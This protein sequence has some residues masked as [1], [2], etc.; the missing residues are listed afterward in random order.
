MNGPTG[1][2]VVIVDPYSSGSLLAPALVEVGLAPVAVV[3][4]DRPPAVFAS[5][6]RPDDFPEIIRFQG[7]VEEV[8]ARLRRLSPIC[9]IPG[10]ESGVELA[11]QL[12]AA[13]TPELANEVALAG[14][15]RHKGLMGAAVAASG[16]PTARQ[17][18]TADPDQVAKWI[19]A[20]GLAGADIVLKPAKGAGTDSVT[21]INSTAD[22]RSVFAGI[23]G[24]RNR[25]DLINEEIVVQEFLSG[26]EY[27]VDTFSF[28]GLH[29][30]TDIC[31]YQKMDINGRTAV[32]DHM[33]WMPYD[34]DAYGE[35]LRYAGG[36]L[37]ALGVRFGPAHTEIMA[38]AD[39]PR[40][41][42]ANA[43]I[44]GG[45]QPR[46]CQEATGDSQ[47]A[48]V[49]RY[50]AGQRDFPAGFTLRKTVR[51]VFLI[52]RRSGVIRNADLYE[53]VHE[54][55]SKFFATI[56]VRNGDQVEAT[57]DLFSS[58]ALGFVILAHERSEQVRAD[59]QTI[60]AIEAAL[61]FGP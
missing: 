61:E 31:R 33:D 26:I 21:R 40:L 38:T 29:T 56:G 51:C 23:L 6:Y 44:H 46:F 30:V 5:S 27:V 14:A 16:L 41:I 34:T 52:S 57:H 32:Y 24:R 37:D 3:S 42:E 22:W 9:V 19:A 1:P 28:D 53:R 10:A 35:L 11:D 8:A 60:R 17:L 39:G 47:V 59:Y 55:P 48:R 25:M 13:V 12:A 50:C 15:R 43:R 4:A 2:T 54:L 49:V 7:S 45:G 36:V 18:C 20:E 58:L